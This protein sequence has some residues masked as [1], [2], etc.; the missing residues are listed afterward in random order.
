MSTLRNIGTLMA[1]AIIML[2]GG[3]NICHAQNYSSSNKKAIKAYEKGIAA[4]QQ[5]HGEEASRLMNDALEADNNFMEAHLVLA[6][7]ALDNKN[8]D[9]AKRHY[10]AIVEKDETFWTLSWLE[11]AKIELSLGEND[12]AAGDAK[13]FMALDKKNKDKH[14]EAQRVAENAQFRKEAPRHSS[15]KTWVRQ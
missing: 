5:G 11:L 10:R 12:A 14:A 6:E 2:A 3:L 15:P 8:T 13:K 1:A 7:W 9:E 4:L